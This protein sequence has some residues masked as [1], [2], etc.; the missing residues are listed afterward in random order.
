MKKQ[1]RIKFLSGLLS[2][3]L[4]TTMIIGVCVNAAGDAAAE[5]Y[6]G[7]FDGKLVNDISK[8][9]SNAIVAL[10]ETVKDDQR[11]SLIIEV[12]A[13]SLLDAYEG[14]DKTMSISEFA[15]SDD[16]AALRA[17][18]SEEN[19]ALIEKLDKSG[20]SYEL[21]VSYDTVI[22]GFELIITAR[23]FEDV[24]K[25]LGRKTNVIV[26]EV[27]ERAETQL[28]ENTVNVQDTG[29]F[30][31]IGCG[32]DGSGT[33][34]AVLDTGLDYYHTAFS[35]ENFTAD[36]NSLGMTFSDVEKFI[37]DTVASDK[38]SG[39]TASDV[40][41]SEKVPYGFDY[42]DGDSDVFPIQ[43]DHG[44]HVAGV[45]AGKDD[46]IT[47]VAPNAQLAIMKIFS[48]IVDTARTS[49]ILAALEDCV[50]LEVDVIN[51]SIGTS[52]GFSRENDK[53]QITGVYDRIRALG[54]SMVVA[55]SNSFTSTYGSEKNGN[56]GLTSNPD[57]G[58]VGSPSTYK[59]A[60]SVASINGAKTPYM[61]YG[62][63]II[64]YIEAT[65]RVSEE[66]EF[67]AD[68]LGDGKDEAEYE[69][70]TIPGAGRS[71]DY[72]GI[73]VEGKIVL[74]SRGSTTFEEKA[75]VAEQ[76]GAAG[77][78]IYN[79]V[80]GDIKM[81]VG[82]AKLAVCSIS[83]DEGEM[84]AAAG[85]GTIKIS[86]TQSSGP[87]MSD[88]SSWGPS[89]DLEI[90]P[91]IT[92]HGGMI[93]SSVPGQDY[94][95]ISG[96]SMACPNVS[97][98]VA[99]LRQY[100]RENFP[101]ISD[102]NVEIAAVVNRLLMST[103]DIVKNKNGLPYAVRKQ[104]AGLANLT[105][106]IATD[107]YILTY[108]RRDGSIMDKSKIE[109]GDD[110]AKNGVYTLKFSVYNF[111]SSSLSYDI[112]ACIMTEG[113]SDTK[114]NDGKYTVNEQGYLLENGTSVEITSV[115]NGTLNGQNLTVA[116]GATA[117]VTLTVT[118]SDA[119]KEYLN[120]FENG[121]YVEGYVIL[122]ATAGTEISLS[123]P[124]LA[125]YGD[126]TVAPLFD[127]DYFETNA[128]ELDDSID[129]A[130]KTLP[131]AYATRPVG[132]LYQD[133]VSFLG[134]YY[135]EQDPSSKLIAADRKYISI[136]NVEGTVHALE[137]VWGGL[138]RSA[139][140]IEIT[141]TNDATGEVV[142]SKTEKD[143]RKSYGDGGSIYPANI[144]IGFDAI[145]EELE[146][147]S[148][149]TCLI[150]G[151]LDYGDGG[152]NTNLNNT[153]E[154]PIY[155]DFQAPAVTDVEYYTEYDRS[156]EKTRLFA[157]VSI[158]DNHYSMGAQF[159][160][161]ANEGE[162]GFVFNA[163]DKYITSIYSDYNSTSYVVYELTDYV[164]RIKQNAYNRNTFAIVTYDY[165]LNTATYEIS[166]PDKY[167][168]MY[169]EEESVKLSPNETYELTPV[170]YPGSE[171]SELLEYHS[172]N[173]DVARVVG[174]KVVA[175]KAGETRIVA[176]DPV[177]KKTAHL[178]LTVLG[179]NDEG[180]QKFDKPVTDN[181][182][183]TG[184]YTK[185]AYYQLD[186][187]ERD[188][189]QTGDE[190][191]F[192][193]ENYALS[194]YPSEAV[195]LR[196][197][198]DAY[199]PD[200]YTVRFESSNE[201]IVTVD[202]NGN[203]TAMREG[204]AS[205]SANVMRIEKITNAE[206]KTETVYHPT[207]Y[208][209][210]ISV[211]VKE[212]WITSGP[213]LSHYFGLGGEVTFPSTLAV[214]EIGQFAFSNFDYVPK[215]EGDEI[216]EEVPET[217]KM[218]YLGDDTI[219]KVVIPEGV[220]KI[221]RFAFANLTALREVVLPSTL[222]TIDYGAFY[223]CSSLI[224]VSGIQ[225]VK[226][227]NE[228]AFY[229]C[230]LS[231]A[232]EFGET[233]AIGEY[234]FANNK[235]LKNLTLSEKTKSVASY[236][237]YGCEM[238]KK[239]TIN[240]EKI[241]IGMSVFENCKDLREIAINSA[242]I[243]AG[244]FSGCVKLENVT[245]GRDV[246]VIGEHA[247]R[248]TAVKSFTVADGNTTF[249]PQSGKPYLLSADGKTLLLCAPTAETVEAPATVTAVGDGAFSGNPNLT[250][251]K[252]PGVTKLGNY[253]F[254]DCEALVSFEFGK[255]TH[256]GNYA[257]S[258]TALTETPDLSKVT[259]I[260]DGAFR[261]T[262][263]KSVTVANSTEI[264]KNAFRGCK[265]LESVKLGNNV[266]VGDYA[267]ALD[268][269]D[270]WTY[271][272]YR[273]PDNTRVY[274]YVYT[275]PLHSLT[276][277][278]GAK[279]GA[280]AFYGASE[281]TSVTL[282]KNAEIG[283]YAFYN[284]SKLADIDLSKVISI[285]Q[286]AFSGDQTYE[287]L[288]SG[289]S[290]IATDD[291]GLYRYHYH[292][293]VFEK[294]DLSSAEKVGKGAFSY[295]ASLR[296]VKLGSKLTEIADAVFYMSTSLS[297]ISFSKI[298]K[299]G[300][301]AFGETALVNLDLSSVKE[302]GESAFAFVPTLKSVKFSDGVRIGKGAFGYTKSLTKL[303]NAAS[304]AFVDDYAFA[305]SAIYEIDLTNAEYVGTYAFIKEE[306]APF[307]V[308]LGEKLTDIGDNPFAM[309]DI[310]PFS[311]I[312][313]TEFNGKNYE[314]TVFDFELSE[315]VL[316]IAGSLY[317]RVPNGLELI[318]YAGEGK[319]A[320]VAE[321][322]V[323][324]SAMSFAGSD[325]KS[326]SLPK[327]LNA[328]GHKAFFACEDLTLVTFKSYN[329]PVLEEEFDY[330]YYSTFEN[331]PATGEYDFVDQNGNEFTLP[332]LG[333]VDH[334]MWN[335]TDAPYVVYYGANFIDYIGHIENPITMVYPANGKNYDSFVL[336][337]YFDTVVLGAAAADDV[338]LAAIAL[339][340]SLPETVSL[341]DRA[342]V[343]QARA[344]YDAI[345][346][347]EQ[348]ALV[349]NYQKLT[350][351]E[352]R[353]E[354]LLTLEN[355]E[356]TTPPDDSEEKDGLD[357]TTIILIILTSILAAVVVTIIIIDSI[358]ARKNKKNADI[359]D[360]YVIR[361]SKRSKPATPDESAEEG[362]EKDENDKN[363]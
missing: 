239:V 116:A 12:D 246:A 17:A 105:S 263:V 101:A 244:S 348:R 2:I 113:I 353:I 229:G 13:E 305:Y 270:N 299:I 215:E 92:A 276:V 150:K 95:R 32:Y 26:G 54:I 309:C 124:F 333:I 337:Q 208:S 279:L 74:V 63:T 186:S 151:Y 8:Y 258:N 317:R 144:K 265:A 288:D 332:G 287:Y 135:F 273:L 267:F 245:I 141:I 149:F 241:K 313:I 139:E 272:Y 60:L 15:Q 19:A 202:E 56:L 177:T 358:H 189:G 254:A 301:S 203:I 256:I 307:A 201:N 295:I 163:F 210:S 213:S 356:D 316:V 27:Y 247:F 41:I 145:D 158:Y 261:N 324:L 248:N 1:K 173:M 182:V 259:Y 323:R 160:Y 165:A 322:T 207:Y 278:E 84:L 59:G 180:Y 212:P 197:I 90:K 308:K 70:V 330:N 188:I 107:A 21:G 156:A 360:T 143:V 161:V 223:G 28:V 81:T 320:E 231:G 57:N 100:V 363:D 9:F 249:K 132:S 52:A 170:L 262:P 250:S 93:L 77:I 102:N 329:A 148:K 251:V 200:E 125:F 191:K 310:A 211:E 110:P 253:A 162:N 289:F 33:V 228:S 350:E 153:F 283:D 35:T 185:K 205:I 195:T 242:V 133:Y 154:F 16:A 99:I 238:L 233:V 159:G 338:T 126:W 178:A 4:L 354:K 349:T 319:N 219:T 58:T 294:I 300:E 277:G 75:Q 260:G 214:T 87:F 344:A 285:G 168:D 325:V 69:F 362:E 48:D 175:I 257:F 187:T 220:E 183:L 298:E 176:R 196:Y 234:A 22:A 230:N 127:I 166:L 140:R 98:L 85:T 194:L 271:D 43:S 275:S 266:K 334:F 169:F 216:S 37:G 221:G 67:V 237:F 51:M 174:N 359:N 274:F 352:D 38:Q 53:E 129:L 138:L 190:M 355:P 42:A 47:G 97:G 46:V 66:K 240:A 83:Q 171:W 119:D 86:K 3:L 303:E 134:S 224:T 30:N 111:G 142:F 72:T 164:Q 193:G 225:N 20:I 137:Y 104:G 204:F 152:E 209:K 268:L 286:L 331:L 282:G 76:K 40:Y 128:D 120:K 326:V 252:L 45:I 296:S 281:L 342:L 306:R 336:G 39:L 130:D 269:T 236:A 206:G 82:D 302:I 243:P 347:I 290:A 29:I 199:F 109:L 232:L 64:Y 94:D 14:S 88:F 79:N 24:C 118:I 112:S 71:A 315:N 18:I 122:T 198:F 335:A 172:T 49:W 167:V 217:T 5:A 89:P 55:A 7:L 146:N 222:T 80:A 106:A 25:T 157:K 293:P 351:A 345:S 103:G 147:N 114:T 264:G 291:E 121:M 136:S 184:F 31:S 23:D 297:D 312:K 327:E 34:V 73:E 192:V 227:I 117:D 44:T 123:A 181:F 50:V 78:I 226:F 68:L 346:T 292:T 11:I 304:I 321:G 314:E 96:T 328:I 357:T 36:R 62:D 218:W 311:I 340:D 179:E 318:T 255:L 10:P 65:D 108:D 91:E 115:S 6:I 131:D 61:L 280:G 341:D 339:I 284:A 235:N 155:V 343:E 361:R